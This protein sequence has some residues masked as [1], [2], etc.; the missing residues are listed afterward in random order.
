MAFRALRLSQRLS[1]SLTGTDN[2][3]KAPEPGYLALLRIGLAA[4]AGG[5]D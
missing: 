1:R 3:M 4:L 2:S 5:S